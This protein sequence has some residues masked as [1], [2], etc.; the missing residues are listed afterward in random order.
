MSHAGD[1][2]RRTA[3]ETED[4]A[5]KIREWINSA[6]GAA[7]LLEAQKAVRA[8][9]ETAESYSNIDPELLQKPV[10]L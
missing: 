10:T 5:L 8:A 4:L 6:E 3:V 7:K 1:T 2:Q 9:I